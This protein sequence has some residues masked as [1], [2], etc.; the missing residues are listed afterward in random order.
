M[1]PTGPD[2]YQSCAVPTHQNSTDR[3]IEF[4]VEVDGKWGPY[5]PCN[6]RNIS[7]PHGEWSC[8]YESIAPPRPKNMPAQCKPFNAYTGMAYKGAVV[9]TLTNV[10][11]GDC[12]SAVTRAHGYMF[13]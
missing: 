4:V 5:L 6:P 3:I 2:A 10:D 8:G 9:K 11:L 12:C 7:N 13:K 1:A